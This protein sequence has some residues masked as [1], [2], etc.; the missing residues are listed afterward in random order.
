MSLSLSPFCVCGLVVTGGMNID[1][2]APCSVTST[3]YLVLWL[4]PKMTELPMAT[5]NMFMFRGSMHMS[6]MIWQV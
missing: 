3:E 6:G 5:L 1:K 2:E 4:L